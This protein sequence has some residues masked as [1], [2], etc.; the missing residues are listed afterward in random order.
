MHS[1]PKRRGERDLRDQSVVLS[2][3]LDLHPKHLPIPDL[4]RDLEGSGDAYERAIRDLTGVGLLRCPGC[5][6][7]PTEA[8]LRFDSLP[9]P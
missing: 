9:L 6:V 2:R 1:Q 5:V 7:E 8:A 3:V 4:V